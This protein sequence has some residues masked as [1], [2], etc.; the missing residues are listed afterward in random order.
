[1]VE[2]AHHRGAWAARTSV[3]PI[4]QASPDPAKEIT[5][6]IQDAAALRNLTDTDL[7]IGTS[8]VDIRGWSVKDTDGRIVGTVEELMIDDLQ[9]R[10]RFLRVDLAGFIG[11]GEGTSCLPIESVIRINDSD[12]VIDQADGR[13]QDAPRYDPELVVKREFYDEHYGPFG[14]PS[15]W[16][17]TMSRR[18]FTSLERQRK[19]P[20]KV[21]HMPPTEA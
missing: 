13:L 6:P 15:L 2:C 21:A 11:P 4:S 18:S 10:V 5:M 12:V 1:V 8:D 17:T 14:N 7:T 9:Y 19:A 16:Q 3:S 20:L